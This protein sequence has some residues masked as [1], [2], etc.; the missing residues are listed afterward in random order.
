MAELH[1]GKS[2]SETTS[3]LGASPSAHSTDSPTPRSYNSEV[4]PL[5][6]S[7]EDLRQ[8]VE[9][10]LKEL[11][12]TSLSKADAVFPDKRALNKKH[13]VVILLC[14]CALGAIL[15]VALNFKRNKPSGN[16]FVPGKAP[17]AF[18]LLDPVHDL[19]L[20]S[21][22]REEI[23][24]PPKALFAK[25]SKSSEHRTYPTNAWYQNLLMLRGEPSNVH[26]VYSVPYLL[27]M[28]GY[29]PGLRAHSNHILASTSVL[30]LTFTEEAGITL[31]AAEDFTHKAS[32][33]EL[34][35]QY[36]ILETTALGLTLQWVSQVQ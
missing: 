1:E 25:K 33:K 31:G 13:T 4:L 35:H 9:L 15:L 10:H 27:D 16:K 30:Q 22:D 23:T 14:G 24:G 19:K 34:S 7:Y 29:I 3:L 5:A 2:A 18:S 11:N 21:F 32:S 8:S 12:P 26:R 28:V 6:S 17:L 36:K 20:P